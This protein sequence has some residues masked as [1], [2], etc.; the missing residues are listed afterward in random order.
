VEELADVTVTAADEDW[1]A[2]FTRRLVADRLAACGNIVPRVRSIYSW[3]GELEDD[4]EALVILHTRKS[5]VPA[6][7]QRAREEHPYDVPQVIALPVAAANPDYVD[8]LLGATRSK[9]DTD[10]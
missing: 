4:S 10:R 2:E 3:D 7:I 5:L 8:W 6:V 1:L 9:S